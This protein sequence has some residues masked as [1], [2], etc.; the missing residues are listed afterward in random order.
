MD[1]F[2]MSRKESNQIAI[3][4]KLQRKEITQII[5]AQMLH[6]TS[7]QVRNKLDRYNRQ[8]SSGLIHKRRGKPGNRAWDSKIKADA[9]L[10]IREHYHD[11]G[12]AFAAEKLMQNHDIFVNRETL[13]I[14]MIQEGLW[15]NKIRKIK[16]RRWRERKTCFGIMIQVDGSDHDWFESRAPRCTLLVFIDDATSKIVWAEFV[17]G[18]SVENLMHASYG[19]FRKHG[20]PVSL[21]VDHASVFSVNKANPDRIKITQYERAMKELSVEMI[22]ANSSQAK[23]RVERV[24]K[25]LQDRLVKELR[26][27]NISSMDAGNRFLREKYLNEHNAKFAVA[28]S[29]SSDAHRSINGYSLDHILCIKDQRSLAN[30]FTISYETRLLQIESQVKVAIRPKDQVTV[31]RLLDNSLVLW[32]RNTTLSFTEITQKPSKPIIQRTYSNAIPIKPA[33]NH[34]WGY[35]Q[36]KKP[37]KPSPNGGYFRNHLNF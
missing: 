15:H 37:I 14:A 9:M 21:Y 27:A 23:G 31:L 26:L 1:H 33:S 20:L 4:E 19:Y 10:L 7:R 28:A 29:D 34:P 36:R 11:F 32:L 30:D 2:T 24:N 5:A 16:H 22:H 18:E 25:T 17:T 35:Q 3:F 6:L 13:R 12:P 8:G